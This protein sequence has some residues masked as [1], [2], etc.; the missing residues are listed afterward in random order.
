MNVMGRSVEQGIS[1]L[2]ILFVLL[3]VGFALTVLFRVGPLYLDDYTV[4]KSFEALGDGNTRTLS[5]Q[6]IRE[7]LYKYF[8]VN[9]VDNIDL[10]QVRVDR[11]PARILVSLYYER[12][13]QFLG[14]LDVVA[15][16]NNVYDSSKD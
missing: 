2:G 13:V 11:N 12:R 1:L 16:F 10:K 7:K 15:K 6:A 5:D 9:N 4:R 3:L 14:N 8:V